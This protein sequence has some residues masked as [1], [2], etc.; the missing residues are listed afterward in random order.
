MKALPLL[1]AALLA[2]LLPFLIELP[3][4]SEAG[5]RLFSVFLLAVVLFARGGLIG[6]LAGE[7][8]GG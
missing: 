6:L 1:L 2:Y 4:L 7:K 3:G 8:R 5:H